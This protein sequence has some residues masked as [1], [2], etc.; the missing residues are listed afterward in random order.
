MS[1]YCAQV[2]SPQAARVTQRESEGQ[3]DV[4]KSAAPPSVKILL[5]TERPDGFFLRRFTEDGNLAHDT[6]HETLDD[7][8]HRAYSEYGSLSD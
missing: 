1:A 7:A 4:G 3:S 8:M 6:Q 5:I 2:L